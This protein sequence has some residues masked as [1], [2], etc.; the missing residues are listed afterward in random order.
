MSSTTHREQNAAATGGIV[1][2]PE[3]SVQEI[4]QRYRTLHGRLYNL[5]NS[6]VVYLY[7]SIGHSLSGTYHGTSPAIS[8]AY[9][10]GLVVLVHTELVSINTGGYVVGMVFLDSNGQ[11][12]HSFIAPHSSYLLDKLEVCV[13]GGTLKP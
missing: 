3:M 1:L 6:P 4:M 8:G 13:D 5:P 12:A 9:G 2:P 10:K 7:H 11:Q